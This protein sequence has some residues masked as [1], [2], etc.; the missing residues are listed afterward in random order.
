MGTSAP[1][2]LRHVLEE[3]VRQLVLETENLFTA[4]RDQAR[5]DMADQLNQAVRRIRQAADPEDLDRTLVD[6]TAPFCASAA[7]FG[8]AADFL[9]GGSIRGVSD[10]VAAEFKTLELP[11]VLA[12]AL[13]GAVESQDPV[14]TATT[15]GEISAEI[16]KLFDHAPADRAS[17]YPLMTG[18]RVPALLYVWGAVQG[19]A[20][21][22]L[23]QAASLVWN[24]VT[25]PPLASPALELAD[26]APGPAIGLITIAGAA[27]TS[28]AAAPS[29]PP[30]KPATSWEELSPEEQ[31]IHLRAQR[32]ARV[33]VSEM[34]LFEPDAVQSGRA[35]GNLYH[36]LRGRIDSARE[37]FRNSFFEP[38]SSMVDYLHVE[39]VQTLAN[40]NP[41][42]LGSDY[43]GPLV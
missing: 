21:E 7:V 1:T 12:P 40:D 18:G 29:P 41:E 25:A 36:A 35:G 6:T 22:L 30:P 2:P 17:I 4:A 20:V 26:E 23:A 14:T 27:V 5:G 42:L 33:Q 15:P 31:R 43:P 10:S 11:I 9:Q 32:F 28:D 37:T 34:R 3:R 38:C 8:V 24:S 13:R 16:A 39:L 19:P